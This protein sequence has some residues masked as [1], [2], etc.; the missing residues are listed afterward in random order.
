MFHY[1]V[2]YRVDAARTLEA[3]A[4]VR[5]TQFEVEAEVGTPGRLLTKRDE[6]LLWME[7][8]ENVASA[9]D[10]EAALARAVNKSG[11]LQCLA[12]AS[13]RHMECF[14]G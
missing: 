14:E 4:A 3:D 1:Y 13:Q 5:Q 2:Y 6:P 7:I 10:F 12:T 9:A 11:V 8:Y